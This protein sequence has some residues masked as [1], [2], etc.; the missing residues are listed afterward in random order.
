MLPA[1]PHTQPT[2]A[3]LKDIGVESNQ[4][5][6]L[7]PTGLLAKIIDF[8]PKDS[9]LSPILMSWFGDAGTKA[10]VTVVDQVRDGFGGNEFNPVKFTNS[11]GQKINIWDSV[12]NGGS[13]R[14]LMYTVDGSSPK[15]VQGC[16]A[17]LCVALAQATS[18]MLND[19]NISEADRDL[20]KTINL[21]GFIFSG[22][23]LNGADLS[24]LSL[25]NAEF[26]HCEL[27]GVNLTNCKLQGANFKG[28]SD[29]TDFDLTG[30]DL[31][32]AH[33]DLKIPSSP[34]SPHVWSRILGQIPNQEGTALSMIASI[35]DPNVRI[36]LVS[37]IL[38]KL[39]YGSISSLRTGCDPR[40]IHVDVDSSYHGSR[41]II[42]DV[43]VPF[44]FSDPIY[45]QDEGISKYRSQIYNACIL[46]KIEAA[47]K[48]E[49]LLLDLNEVH[50]IIEN[51]EALLPWMGDVKRDM[52]DNKTFFEKFFVLCEEPGYESVKERAG[53]LKHIFDVSGL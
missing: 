2:Q 30:C 6:S 19:T 39:D 17:F 42:E 28:I 53:A 13:E 31:S 49:L 45:F 12:S 20:F 21:D 27:K 43:V 25:Q 46:P 26:Q 32:G 15:T 18:Q 38:N 33:I 1:K 47:N 9:P 36:K 29:F 24:G 7:K 34:W 8:L 41:T 22:S 11:Q 16:V 51:Y 35:G 52:S 4:I 48:G 37:Q 23:Q 10:V 44:L 5:L 50:I 40:R 14:K 3:L